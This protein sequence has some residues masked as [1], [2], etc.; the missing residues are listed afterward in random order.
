MQPF[1]RPI[2]TAE[3]QHFLLMRARAQATVRVWKK[4]PEPQAQLRLAIRNFCGLPV[5]AG[6]RS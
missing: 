4:R 3:R 1:L 6:A 5:A 2:D